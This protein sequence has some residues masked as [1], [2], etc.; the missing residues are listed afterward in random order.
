MEE[1]FSPESRF[2]AVV[3]EE[4]GKEDGGFFEGRV[5]IR[6]WDIVSWAR[7]P[8]CILCMKFVPPL[9]K[10]SV[11]TGFVCLGGFPVLVAVDDDAFCR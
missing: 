2:A 3:M 11:L 1:A 4:A 9:S 10:S 8:A 7:S 6:G 5:S